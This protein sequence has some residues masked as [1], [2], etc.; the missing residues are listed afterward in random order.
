[1]IRI[2]ILDRQP[3]VHGGVRYLLSAFPNLE[4][5]AEAYHE[6]ELFHRAPPPPCRACRGRRSQT[7]Y[8]CDAQAFAA[9]RPVAAHDRL[10]GKSRRSSDT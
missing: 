3:L 9:G 8:Q 7:Q 4:I 10:Y 6:D 1:M 5:S 2:G